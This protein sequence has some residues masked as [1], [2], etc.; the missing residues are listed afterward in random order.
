MKLE[1]EV[2]ISS[3]ILISRMLCTLGL[4]CEWGEER[5]GG[6]VETSHLICVPHVRTTLL[7]NVTVLP[8]L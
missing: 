6:G 2:Q 7:F 5:G 8:D 4:T 1:V 3:V